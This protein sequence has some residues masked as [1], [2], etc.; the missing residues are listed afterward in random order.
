[1]TSPTPTIGHV[2]ILLPVWGDRYVGQC[3]DVCL[4]SLLAPGNLPA[5]AQRHPVS[6]VLLTDACG[7]AAMEA[8]P[9]IAA[10]SS[11]ASVLFEAIDDL[12]ARASAMTLTLAYGRAIRAVGAAMTDTCFVFL[13]GD[14][15][16]AEGSLPNA[17]APIAAGE[18]AVLTGNFQAVAERVLPLLPRCGVEGC[19][20]IAVAP[21]RLVALGLANLHP[22]SRAALVGDSLFHDPDANRLFWRVGDEALLGR[23]FLLHMVAIRPEVS[24]FR[25]A[26]PC[27]YSLVPELCPSGRVHVVTD[28]NA[29]VCLE[30][31]PEGE[32]TGRLAIGPARPRPLAASISAFATARHRRNGESTILFDAALAP[33]GPS[34]ALAAARARADAF[35][36]ELT[37]HLAPEPQP[38][39][40]HPYWAGMAETH[41][42]TAERGLDGEAF[43]RICGAPPPRGTTVAGWR[44]T[45]LGRSP[46]TRPWH[47]RWADGRRVAAAVASHAGQRRVAVEASSASVRAFLERAAAK[48]GASVVAPPSGNDG[49]LRAELAV[50]AV[51]GPRDAEAALAR[52]SARLSPGGLAM[53]VFGAPFSDEAGAIGTGEIEALQGVLDAAAERFSLDGLDA[54]P[55]GPWRLGVQKAMMEALRAMAAGS[56]PRRAAAAARSAAMLV[57]SLLANLGAL[58]ASP[59]AESGASTLILALR[60]K[61]GAPAPSL[62]IGARL[63]HVPQRP[64][65]QRMEEAAAPVP[66]RATP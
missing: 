51:S 35:M 30:L 36:A 55:A 25:I 61:D 65:S 45:L 15:V 2:R 8:H 18:S 39:R 5:L 53:L 28:S 66:R 62:G 46:D 3:L 13:V 47:P 48:A 42:L 19:E 10:L 12:V 63:P 21:R 59:S 9:V 29:Y 52:A 23:F 34:P 38:F 56:G 14:Y 60:L 57:L 4:A 54:V 11:H 6:L 17:V 24:D 31:Q 44:R 40:D 37:G 27:D 41:R 43:A 64:L 22:A 1:M 33:D 50:F 16:L 7:R 58:R 20:A 49:A 26:A 32:R